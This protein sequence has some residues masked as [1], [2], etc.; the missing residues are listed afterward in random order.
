MERIKLWVDQKIG[1]GLGFQ[2]SLE[3]ELENSEKE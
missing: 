1:G 2:F 3:A